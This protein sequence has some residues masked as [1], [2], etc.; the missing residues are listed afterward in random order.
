MHGGKTRLLFKH[1][2]ITL[3]I[4]QPIHTLRKE[5]F[6]YKIRLRK[7]RNR[8]MFS[9]LIKCMGYHMTFSYHRTYLNNEKDLLN[10]NL[11]CY[12]ISLDMYPINISFS[13]QRFFDFK[14]SLAY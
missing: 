13:S 11:V 3:K 14:I 9:I 8:C 12:V 6:Y 10:E 1:S 2:F 5:S 4:Q 7:L